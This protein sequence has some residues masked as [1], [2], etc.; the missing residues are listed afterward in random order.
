LFGG[1]INLEPVDFSFRHSISG[2]LRVDAFGNH[3]FGQGIGGRGKITHPEHIADNHVVTKAGYPII[4]L[5]ES[6]RRYALIRAGACHPTLEAEGF[7]WPICKCRICDSQS[8]EW[9]R[10]RGGRGAL[11][12]NSP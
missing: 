5:S 11:W 8:G 1:R 3:L 9:G 12:Q 6:Q 7:L 2:P 4:R 10:R